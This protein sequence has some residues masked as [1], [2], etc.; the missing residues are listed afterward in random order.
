MVWN[1]KV[2][3]AIINF[4]KKNRFGLHSD[5]KNKDKSDFK[6]HNEG[7]RYSCYQCDYEVTSKQTLKT[8]NEADHEGDEYQCDDCNYQTGWKETLKY[9]VCD[10]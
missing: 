2:I 7:K 6:F 8:H 10:S 5:K 9:T 1:I 3:S 4:K